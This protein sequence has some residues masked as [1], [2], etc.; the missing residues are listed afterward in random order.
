[1]APRNRIASISSQLGG[2]QRAASTSAL[3]AAGI[4][5][6]LTGKVAVI[7]GATGQ[8]GRTMVRTLAKAGADVAVHYRSDKPGAEALC[9]EIS[10]MGRRGKWF[11]NPPSCWAPTIPMLTCATCSTIG[12]AVFADI[13]EKQSVDSMHA[14]IV[15]TLGNPD[16]VVTNAVQQCV[17]LPLYT[18]STPR[19]A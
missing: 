1:M 5:I 18:P 17:V 2:G 11:C 15:G 19:V 9:Q 13:G 14:H 4:A 8:L 16:I 6:D 3:S 12:V 7:T 10:S